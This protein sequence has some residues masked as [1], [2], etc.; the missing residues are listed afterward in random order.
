MTEDRKERVSVIIPARNE[1]ASI[2]RCVLS[3]AAQSAAGLHEI[4][5]VDDQSTDGTPA[6]LDRLQGRIPVLRVVRIEALPAGWLGKC[7]ALDTGSRG[8]S[9]DWL[10]F[11]DADTEH[12]PGSLAA[13]LERARAGGAALFSLSP[14]QLAPTWWEKAVI[15]WIYVW[16]AKR[17]PFDDVNAPDS[18]RAAANGQYLLVRR[19]V[20]ERIGGHSAVRDEILEDV[21]LARK[22]KAAGGRCL[23]LP[24]AQWVHTRMYRTFG[25]M[26]RGWTKNLYELCGH[27]FSEVLAT[28]AELCF[29]DIVPA[30]VLIVAPILLASVRIRGVTPVAIAAVGLAL[31]LW[32][33]WNYA[34]SLRRLGFGGKA[35][36]GYLPGELIFSALLLNS[37][38]AHHWKG[39]VEWKGRHYATKGDWGP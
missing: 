3:V 19:E 18:P 1:E 9:G 13:A 23:F 4:I 22:V 37:A 39:S 26:W 8:A 38:Y 21:A 32:R 29:L 12:L 6:L 24:G 16:L 31:V 2:E 25:E 28:I 30:A 17:Y 7:Y 15:P 11:T 33:H 34:R 20:Y 36:V 35:A 14:G 27:S 5:V 10:L